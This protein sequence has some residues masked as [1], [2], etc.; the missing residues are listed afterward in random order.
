M[1]LALL[2][3]ACATAPE[4]VAMKAPEPLAVYVIELCSGERCQW[5]YLGLDGDRE[6]RWRDLASGRTF[7]EASLMYAWKIVAQVVPPA[8]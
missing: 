1:G 8:S 4:P 2:A 3:A 7:T 5:R 6:P